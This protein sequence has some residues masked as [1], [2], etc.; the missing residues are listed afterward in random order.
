MVI[1]FQI[2]T[3]CDTQHRSIWDTLNWLSVNDNM[4]ELTREKFTNSSLVL[5]ALSC[6]LLLLDH[7][8]ISSATTWISVEE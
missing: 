6:I 8:E 4:M 1:P 2:V 3:D 5:Q 7:L